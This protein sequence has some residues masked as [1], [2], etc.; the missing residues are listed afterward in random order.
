M[1]SQKRRVLNW[2]ERKTFATDTIYFCDAL[3]EAACSALGLSALDAESLTE[4]AASRFWNYFLR[5]IDEDRR[6]GLNS[7]FEVSEP[8]AMKFR[9]TPQTY[10]RSTVQKTRS[11]GFKLRARP[12]ILA[13]IDQL[14]FRQYEAL[15]S[16]I[17]TLAGAKRTKLTPRGNEGGVDFFA[18]IEMPARC[19]LFSGATGPLRLIGQ[20]KKH[21]VRLDVGKIRDFITTIDNIRK[22]QPDVESHVPTWFRSTRGP[23]VGWIVA[24][25][26]FQNG[27]ERAARDHGIVLA[28][29]LDLAEIAALSR[30][31]NVWETPESRLCRIFSMIEI[32]L[33]DADGL[34]QSTGDEVKTW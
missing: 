22:R 18:L 12:Q 5:K 14:D 30:I 9:W 23:I 4:G 28:D 3:V 27:A 20:C 24:H 11:Q 19:H 33:T 26:G 13:M 17:S 21:T 29:S 31:T 34:M 32:A 2:F 15:G 8:S 6:R 25:E 10:L 16:V 1:T 7:L